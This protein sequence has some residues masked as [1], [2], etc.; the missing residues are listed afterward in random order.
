MINNL[1][2]IARVMP[3]VPLA[4][5]TDSVQNGWR[6]SSWT[7]VNMFSTYPIYSGSYLF[8]FY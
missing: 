4:L 6:S 5:Y 1:K 2:K 8:N 3:D 7:T